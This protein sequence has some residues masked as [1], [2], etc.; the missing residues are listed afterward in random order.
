LQ[1]AGLKIET[2][3]L[4]HVGFALAKT[5]HQAEH[6]CFELFRAIRAKLGNRIA[7]QRPG[8]D[9]GALHWQAKPRERR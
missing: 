6:K 2:I 1:R 5:E 3:P 9:P 7:E 4:Q 8:I